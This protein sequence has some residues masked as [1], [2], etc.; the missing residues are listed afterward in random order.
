MRSNLTPDP[1]VIA[2][3]DEGGEPGFFVESHPA[4]WFVTSSRERATVMRRSDAEW[5]L[6]RLPADQ[7]G[8]IVPSPPTN[9]ED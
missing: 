9:E 5:V 3:P 4:K 7:P 8:S 1:V 6:R 2:M